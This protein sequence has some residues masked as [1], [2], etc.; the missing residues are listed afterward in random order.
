MS[1]IKYSQTDEQI[2]QLNQIIK[3]YLKCYINYQQNNWIKLLSAVQF[4]YNNNMQVFTEISSFQAK[5]DKDM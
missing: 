1:I 2:K 4:I 5:Y 3:Q